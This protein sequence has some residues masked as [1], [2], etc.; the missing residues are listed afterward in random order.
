MRAAKQSLRAMAPQFGVSFDRVRVHA[1]VTGEARA[2]AHGVPAVA[3]GEHIYIGRGVDLESAEG[4]R[5]LAHEMAHVVQQT[6]PHD[7]ASAAGGAPLPADAG[8]L[9]AEAHEVG[10]LVAAGGTAAP[11]LRTGGAIAQGYGS[12][13][14]QSMG[15]DVASVLE[16]VVARG[17]DLGGVSD[18]ER[19]QQ[20]GYEKDS[21]HGSHQPGW[22]RVQDL[23]KGYG[24]VKDAHLQ[25]ML[26]RDPFTKDRARSLTISVRNFKMET[27]VA[28][29][30]LG[31]EIDPKTKEAARYDVPVSPG[32]MTAMNG[33]LYGSVENMRKAPVAEVV[34]L[35]KLLDLEAAWERGDMKGK[36]PNFDSLYEKAT[37]WRGQP[38]YG[39]GKELGKAADATGGDSSSYTDLALHNEAHFGQGTD[40]KQ[41]IEERLTVALPETVKGLSEWKQG[42]AQSG[43]EM[44]WLAGHSRALILAREAHDIKHGTAA[45]KHKAQ[46]DHYGHE[47]EVPDT[48]LLDPAKGGEKLASVPTVNPKSAQV[49]DPKAGVPIKRSATG[50][51]TADQKLNDAYVENAGADHYLTDAFA[52]GHQIVRSTMGTVLEE[53]VADMGGRDKFLDYVADKIQDGAIAD[54]EHA[55]G[56]LGEF[57]DASR[58]WTWNIAKGTSWVNHFKDG[59]K[60]VLAAKIDATRMRGIGAKLLHD[61]Y[62]KRGMVVHNKKGATFLI[63]GDGHAAEAPEA[64]EIIALAVLASRDQITQLAAT[65]TMPNPLDVWAYTPDFDK[66][67]FTRLSGRAILEHQFADSTYLWNL[68]KGYFSL[69]DV[70]PKGNQ[71]EV[72]KH[73]RAQ[74]GVAKEPGKRDG[75]SP[76]DVG[77]SPLK[78]WFAKRQEYVRQFQGQAHPGKHHYRDTADGVTIPVEGA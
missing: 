9:E 53:F 46:R 49:P 22:G 39:A 20:V 45:Q 19:K 28:G 5:I 37:A 68:I 6:A 78:T 32:D 76:V 64:R 35:Q 26:A 34:E 11:S 1:D 12:P 62:N 74:Q 29:P 25:E 72:S 33:D 41:A 59:L 50:P 16:P 51:L 17:G 57:Q 38:V 47:T 43:N 42:N 60:Q 77:T 27:D 44:A 23:P 40:L 30:Y 4:K 71:Q 3:E 2:A 31:I 56:E 66:T 65:G 36:A 55:Q 8:A 18:A 15:N 52:A 73:N 10:D 67:Q 63:K 48:G 70:P 13:E 58:E 75:K 61:Y 21:N 14:H 54:K 24:V 7:P 69:G